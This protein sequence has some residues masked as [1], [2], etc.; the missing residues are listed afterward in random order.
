[1]TDIVSARSKLD[2]ILKQSPPSTSNARFNQALTLIWTFVTNVANAIVMYIQA[3]SVDLGRQIPLGGSAQAAS[4][5]SPSPP[6]LSP[7]AAQYAAFVADTA[8]L[9]RQSRRERSRAKKKGPSTSTPAATT[10]SSKPK[11]KK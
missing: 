7:F 11:P 9:R 10:S 8:E 4:V 5:P 2:A 6:P 3:I 1:M